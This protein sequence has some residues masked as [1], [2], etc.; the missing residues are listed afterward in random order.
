MNVK[1][2]Q[3]EFS[4][5]ALLAL[6]IAAT[7]IGPLSMNLLVPSM[8]GLQRAFNVDYGTVQLTLSGYLFA[9]AG[10]QLIHGPLSDRFG[11]RP[12]L[13]CGLIINLI[14]STI[15]FFAPSIYVLIFG[16]IIQAVGGCVG[17]VDRKSVV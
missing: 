15:C 17:M 2:T 16:R 1:P 7:A 13:L 12:V 4:N 3:G 6:V 8:P 5:R 10:A 14:G 9:L 11:R